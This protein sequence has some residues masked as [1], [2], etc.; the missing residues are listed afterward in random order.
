MFNNFDYTIKLDKIEEILYQKNSCNFLA[1]KK[2]NE[3]NNNFI[4]IKYS[5]QTKRTSI[6][7]IFSMDQDYIVRMDLD[8]IDNKLLE[9]W[10]DNKSYGFLEF[11]NKIDDF[12]YFSNRKIIKKYIESTYT[13]SVMKN[14]CTVIHKNVIDSVYYKL[15]DD[16]NRSDSEYKKRHLE[17]IISIIEEVLEKY[18]SE[19][20]FYYYITEKIVW[21]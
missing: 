8:Y 12:V 16:W 15:Q 2:E 17:K 18:K 21:W 5:Q 4:Y 6:G 19:D 1:I 20:N 13:K 11:K 10:F 3:F 14:Y 9:S 7:S